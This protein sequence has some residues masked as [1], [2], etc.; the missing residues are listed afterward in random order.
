VVVHADGVSAFAPPR[1]SAPMNVRAQRAMGTAIL[2]CSMSGLAWTSGY[3]FAGHDTPRM[4]L[5]EALCALE[6]DLHPQHRDAMVAVVRDRVVQGVQALQA[7]G[8][9][10][11]K[12]AL[13]AIAREAAR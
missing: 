13:A 3:C 7:V 2:A 4:G 1:Y 11:A 10:H 5:C 8:G 9:E 12:H 6:T